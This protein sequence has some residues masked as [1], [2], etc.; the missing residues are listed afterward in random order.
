MQYYQLNDAMA[1]FFTLEDAVQL[2]KQVMGLWLQSVELLPLNF[3][4]VTY[5]SLVSNFESELRDVFTFLDI[6][7][8]DAVLDYDAHASQKSMINTPSYEQVTEPIYQSA[9]YR[10]QRYRDQLAPYLDELAPFIDKFGYS[11]AG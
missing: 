11:D 4:V 1:N 10:W 3:H 2:Y 7:W 5:E 6:E 8:D 9:K